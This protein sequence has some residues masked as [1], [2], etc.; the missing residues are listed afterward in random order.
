MKKVVG[1]IC[2]VV[3]LFLASSCGDGRKQIAIVQLGTHMSLDE[4]N[5]AIVEKLEE[6]GYNAG[7]YKISQHN[8]NFSSDVAN[9]IMQTLNNAEVVIAIATPVAQAAFQSLPM[10]K[11]IVFAAVSDPKAA[12]LVE[13]ITAPEGNIT[14]TSDEIQVNLIIDKAK[15]INPDLAK[16]GFIYN[17]NED[18]SVSN[19]KK[20]RAYCETKGIE[21]KASTIQNAG[22]MS[23]VANVLIRDVDAMFVTD[24]N[25]V[26]SGMKI[27]SEICRKAKK[28][29]YTGADSMVRDGGMLCIGINYSTL[30]EYTA[31]MVIDI[32]SGVEIKDIPVKVFNENLKIYLNEDYIAETGISIPDSI[33]TDSNLV[34]V[35]DSAE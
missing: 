17:P 4:I 2:I 10:D 29:C 14:G 12:G 35:K 16:L 26:A 34:K 6:A 20:I 31:Q 13:N 18:N 22:E 19:L 24:D 32:L 33:L 9:Q 23:E 3:T 11:P 15:E 25:T 27:L 1:L 28:P 30:G 8:A 5:Q 21:V 7:K